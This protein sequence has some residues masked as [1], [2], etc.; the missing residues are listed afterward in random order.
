MKM[1]K[2]RNL[3]ILFLLVVILFSCGPK[4]TIM[5]PV[6]SLNLLQKEMDQLFLD[7]AFDTAT[8]GVVVQSLENGEYLYQLNEKKGFMPASNMKIYTT[9]AALVKLGPDYQYKT[10]LFSNGNIENGVLT[11][12]LI[13]RG[14]GDP[15]LTGRYFD[16]NTLAVF[17]SWI[18]RKER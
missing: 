1:N 10:T 11:G 9:A 13:I 5:Q 6:S 16:G 4:P 2:N 3:V 7:P 17:E 18:D 12:D 8:W 15:T 14:S